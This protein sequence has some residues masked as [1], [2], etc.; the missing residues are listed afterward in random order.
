MNFPPAFTGKKKFVNAIIETPRNS[1]YKYK[2]DHK[3]KMFKL[4]KMLPA[5]CAFPLDMGFIPHTKGED[6]DPLDILVLMENP[7]FQGCLIECRL[8]GVIQALQKEKN[9]K[10][11]RNDRFLA[12]PVDSIEYSGIKKISDLEKHKLEDI[13]AFFKFYNK[14]EQKKFDVE[15]IHSPDKAYAMIKKNSNGNT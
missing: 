15:E 5:G 13:I 11:V 2:F 14:A 1:F 4:G 9:K 6:G 7:S 10:A 12:V 3:T 8:L